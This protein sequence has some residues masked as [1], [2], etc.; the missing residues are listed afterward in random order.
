LNFEIT[1]AAA[2]ACC[3]F[4]SV[5]IVL[6]GSPAVLSMWLSTLKLDEKKSKHTGLA[7]QNGFGPAFCH[8]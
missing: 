7:H 8:S 6:T 2:A 4:W 1:A 5:F 3:C